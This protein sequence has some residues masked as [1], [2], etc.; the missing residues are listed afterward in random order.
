M[1]SSTSTS[2]EED[3]GQGEPST[4]AD[5]MAL[6]KKYWREFRTYLSYYLTVQ[7]DRLM[8]SIRG[9]VIGLAISVLL[10]IGLGAMLVMAAVQIC[11]GIA[12]L[13]TMAFGGRVWAGDLVTGAIIWIAVLATAYFGVSS[14]VAR[15]RKATM[16][17]YEQ[18]RAEQRAAVGRDAEERADE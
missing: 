15:S 1:R 2:A 10:L 3:E 16:E 17:K 8:L 6:A 4:M 14:M 9:M 13:L 7:M 18:L 12:E 5:A 11:S